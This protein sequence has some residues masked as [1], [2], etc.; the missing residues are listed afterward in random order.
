MEGGEVGEAKATAK[1]GGCHGTVVATASVLPLCR[2]AP[3]PSCS[4]LV[5]DCVGGGMTVLLLAVA[6][7]VSAVVDALLQT[8]AA[9]CVK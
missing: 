4:Y 5:V 9:S 7:C 8:R 6:C 1:Q 2:V 3:L